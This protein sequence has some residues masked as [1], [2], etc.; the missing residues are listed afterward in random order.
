MSEAILTTPEA[1]ERLGVSPERVRQLIKTG[2]LPSQQFGRD[3]VIN[4][5]DLALVADRKPGRP[6]KPKDEGE[7]ATGAAEVVTA[8]TDAAKAVATAAKPKRTRKAKDAKP[9]R[10]GKKGKA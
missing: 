8:T 6:P 3:H 10:A 7:P 9:K 5:S 2:R 1:A 4:E